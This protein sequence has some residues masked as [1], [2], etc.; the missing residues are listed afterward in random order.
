MVAESV[1]AI[2][3]VASNLRPPRLT[4]ALFR[5]AYNRN[6]PGAVADFDPAQFFS[7]F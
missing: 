4:E 2:Y 6:A 1:P 5:G 3:E 7:R